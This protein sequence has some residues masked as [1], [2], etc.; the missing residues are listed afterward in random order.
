MVDHIGSSKATSAEA[1]QN[2]CSESCFSPHAAL[3]EN[4]ATRSHSETSCVGFRTQAEPSERTVPYARVLDAHGWMRQKLIG[5]LM[6]KPTCEAWALQMARCITAIVGFSNWKLACIE[7]LSFPTK[8]AAYAAAQPLADE[9]KPGYETTRIRGCLQGSIIV[10]YVQK[11]MY[12]MLDPLDPLYH[13]GRRCSTTIAYC[14]HTV[15][16]MM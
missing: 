1:Q 10:Q 11:G 2:R 14:C 3:L 15:L 7:D 5:K 9:C 13:H 4:V 16:T 6:V 12:K 8:S